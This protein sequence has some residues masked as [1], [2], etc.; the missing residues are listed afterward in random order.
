MTKIETFCRSCREPIDIPSGADDDPDILAAIARVGVICDV[1]MA[2]MKRPKV[3]PMTP[4]FREF[5][6]TIADP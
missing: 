5:R 6:A 1:C 3:K 4:V 2:T